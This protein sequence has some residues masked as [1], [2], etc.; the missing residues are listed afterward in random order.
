MRIAQNRRIAE[1]KKE[2]QAM[3]KKLLAI[4]GNYQVGIIEDPQPELSWPRKGTKSRSSG[5]GSTTL[6]KI[7][8]LV[9]SEEESEQLIQN[10]NLV[11]ITPRKNEACRTQ[12]RPVCNKK[13]KDSFEEAFGKKVE[14]GKTKK[15]IP[16]LFGKSA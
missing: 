2:A 3:Q 7:I 1:N 14:D 12:T 11:P 16:K 8:D 9:N 13:P 4:A 5:G 6:E 15:K 10:A